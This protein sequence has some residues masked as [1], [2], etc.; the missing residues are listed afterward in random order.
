M[1]AYNLIPWL[2]IIFVQLIIPRA[3]GGKVPAIIVFVDS[4]VDTG[5]NNQL[6]TI[7][8]GNFE[9]YGRDFY[10]KMATGRFCNGIWFETICACLFGSNV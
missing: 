1:E 9:P 6:L 8:K 7:L 4:T 10:G 2:I 3:L 5:N